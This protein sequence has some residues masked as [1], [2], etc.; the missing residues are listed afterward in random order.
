MARSTRCPT[1]DSKKI[2]EEVYLTP[3]RMNICADC[4]EL[5]CRECGQA[6]DIINQELEVRHRME[7]TRPK[8][9]VHK[10]E[11]VRDRRAQMRVVR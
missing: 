6:V 8:C 2:E 3:A 5:L 10:A 1:C 11:I 7:L 9:S 4:G